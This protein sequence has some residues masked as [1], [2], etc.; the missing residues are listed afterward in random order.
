[1]FFRVCVLECMKRKENCK[2]VIAERVVVKFIMFVYFI[3][4]LGFIRIILYFFF[5]Y[6]VLFS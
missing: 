4:I 1:M 5:V 6:I 2:A 3:S